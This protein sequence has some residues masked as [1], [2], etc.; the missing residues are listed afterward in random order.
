MLILFQTLKL[1]Q[2]Y[3]VVHI[4]SPLVTL[5]IFLNQHGKAT[6]ANSSWTEACHVKKLMDKSFLDVMRTSLVL[7]DLQIKL[8]R[9]INVLFLNSSLI[10]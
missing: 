9:R 2:Q 7:R 10:K 6:K 8:V 5:L 1:S 3:F 4:L